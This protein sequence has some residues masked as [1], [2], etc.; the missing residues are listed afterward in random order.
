MA[1]VTQ[2]EI[3]RD[4]VQPLE[5]KQ[6]KQHPRKLGAG[7]AMECDLM[8]QKF[9]QALNSQLQSKRRLVHGLDLSEPTVDLCVEG[10]ICCCARCHQRQ[11]CFR[12]GLPIPQI[13]EQP[14]CF[15]SC[16]DIVQ[17]L[18]KCHF[19]SLHLCKSAAHRLA[20]AAIASTNCKRVGHTFKCAQASKT[21]SARIFGIE[22]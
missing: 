3:R 11:R 16:C 12:Q 18:G 8:R 5:I 20:R 22:P 17:Y 13:V 21:L 15:V 6:A 19:G 9:P 4:V 1:T 14:L 10:L 7:W 2:Y